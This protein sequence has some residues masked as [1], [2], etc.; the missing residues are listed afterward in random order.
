[1]ESQKMEDGKYYTPEIEEFHVG[2]KYQSLRGSK[3]SWENF[4]IESACTLYLIMEAIDKK[5]LS[6]EDFRVKYLDDKD[7][8]SLGWINGSNYGLSAFVLNYGD[9]N[10]EFQMYFHDD[11][12][13]MIYNFSGIIFSGKIKNKSEFKK[14]MQQ[15]E[16]NII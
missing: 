11:N 13:I 8:Q 5:L 2:F 16:I 9:K 4:Y 12:L 15:L 10:N 3:K 1:M 14:L 7:I 6:L